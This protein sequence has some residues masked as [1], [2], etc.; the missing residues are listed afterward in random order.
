MAAHHILTYKH[1]GTASIIIILAVHYNDGALYWRHIRIAGGRPRKS[2]VPAMCALVSP[3]HGPRHHR[4]TSSRHT[5]LHCRAHACHLAR[6]ILL[7]AMMSS[8]VR[9]CAHTLGGTGTSVMPSSS[10]ERAGKL[11]VC[12]QMLR[13]IHNTL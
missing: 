8:F 12:Q 6:D 5:C 9:R 11:S 10:F 4:D 3:D 1:I 13:N 2:Q 7:W